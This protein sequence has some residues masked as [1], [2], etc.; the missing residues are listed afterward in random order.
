MLTLWSMMVIAAYGILSGIMIVSTIV[1]L[2]YFGLLPEQG[3][4]VGRTLIIWG[5]ILLLYS[6]ILHTVT[7]LLIEPLINF[8]RQK[9]HKVP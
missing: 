7:M 4:L 5:S 8:A 6:Y 9:I 3:E 1:V 2:G